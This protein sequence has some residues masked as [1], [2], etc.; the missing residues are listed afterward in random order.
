MLIK[1]GILLLF[2]GLV[3]GISFS[4]SY[5]NEF[6][7]KITKMDYEEKIL[8]GPYFG[9]PGANEGDMQLV[10]RMPEGVTD[11]KL[12]YEKLGLLEAYRSGKPLV[13]IYY[14]GKD[15]CNSTGDAVNPKVL[16]NNHKAVLRYAEKHGTAPPLYIYENPHG[17]EKYEGILSWIPDPDGIFKEKF[18]KFPY[19]CKSFVVISPKGN[20]RAIFGEFPISQIDVALKKL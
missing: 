3:Q 20:Y 9:V 19:P 18:F 15:E 8:N 16:A 1:N 2:F 5:F 12:F 13:V 4:Q 7:R 17:L 6:G 10:H 14:P 11:S